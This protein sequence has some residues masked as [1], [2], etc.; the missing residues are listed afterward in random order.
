MGSFTEK[1]A[2]SQSLCNF[3]ENDENDAL[4]SSSTPDSVEH[5][6]PPPD[7]ALWKDHDNDVGMLADVSNKVRGTSDNQVI[8]NIVQSLQNLQSVPYHFSST[9]CENGQGRTSEQNNIE[10]LVR[11]KSPLT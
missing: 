9:D 2:E 8:A 11:I 10:L 3:E 1:R 5:W 4:I 6:S 7:S